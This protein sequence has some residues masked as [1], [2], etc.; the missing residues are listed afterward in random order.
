M[1]NQDSN[2][3]FYGCK[4]SNKTHKWQCKKYDNLKDADSF[5]FNNPNETLSTRIVVFNNL[6]SYLPSYYHCLK[7]FYKLNFPVKINE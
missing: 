6:E 1:E 5:A 7:L 3:I 4:L 2:Y